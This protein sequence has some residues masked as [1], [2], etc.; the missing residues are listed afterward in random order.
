[1][2]HLVVGL[3]LVA[4]LTSGCD[5]PSDNGAFVPTDGGTNGLDTTTFGILGSI[6]N[7]A[8]IHTRKSTDFADVC[9]I[10][11]DATSEDIACYVDVN[12]GDLYH[13]GLELA[14]N[15]PADMCYYLRIEPYWYYNQDVGYGPSTIDISLTKDAS[16]AT[17]ASSCDFD[18]AGAGACT[19]SDE[20][21]VNTDDGAVQCTYDRSEETNRSNCCFGD[22][23]INLSIN[24]N[25]T[26]T[27]SETDG[28]WGGDWA[29]CIGGPGRTNWTTRTDVGLP[30]PAE[31]LVMG[32]KFAG[33]FAIPAPIDTPNDGSNYPI[34]NYYTPAAHTHTGFVD[35]TVST[36]PFFVDP[37]DDLGGTPI[38]S[39]N[40]AYTFEC[41]DQGYEVVNRIS[42]Y[43]RDWDVYS[44]FLAYIGGEGTPEDPDR[45]L[46]DDE[47]TDCDGVGVDCNDRW[48][49]DD[50]VTNSGGYDTSAPGNREGFF[51]FEVY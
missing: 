12:E 13:N 42:V 4:V 41:L 33:S 21:T 50:F 45:G 19:A 40:P 30:A 3:G 46:S 20:V 43:V 17:T 9:E 32:Q 6:D 22:Y 37:I 44:D 25:G 26:I 34:A 38:P 39:G 14:Y 5:G 28:K 36:R 27:N 2:R 24:N 15:I 8:L 1:M 16:G 31:Y 49:A 35:A 7:A 11:A 29:N 51:P 48:D 47:G 10:A 18:G 23:T